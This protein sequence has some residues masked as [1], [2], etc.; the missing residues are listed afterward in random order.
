MQVLCPLLFLVLIAQHST[1][2]HSTAQHS[3]AQHSTAQHSKAQQSAA[4]WSWVVLQRSLNLSSLIYAKQI[5]QFM[6]FSIDMLFAHGGN[7]WCLNLSHCMCNA[8]ILV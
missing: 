4:C 8:V 1:A 7:L 5:A 3:T 2:Q 6:Q